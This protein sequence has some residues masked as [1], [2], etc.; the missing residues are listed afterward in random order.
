[1]RISN[2]LRSL[3]IG[4]AVAD[5][6]KLFS[7]VDSNFQQ[8]K[9]ALESKL[10]FG[11][12]I[13]CDIVTT[14]FDSGAPTQVRLN[15]LKMARSGILFGSAV[16]TFGPVVVS[17]SGDGAAVTLYFAQNAKSVTATVVLF[18]F[19]TSA[20]PGSLI[21]TAGASGLVRPDGS[22]ITISDTGVISST[23][24]VPAVR[25]VPPDAYDDIVWKLDELATP[26][27]NSG[28]LGSSAAYQL[29]GFGTVLPGHTALFGK[30][31]AQGYTNTDGMRGAATYEPTGTVCVS[32]WAWYGVAGGGAGYGAIA[33]GDGFYKGYRPVGS[34]AAPF[35]ALECA[36]GFA[37]VC[38]GGAAHT[39]NANSIWTDLLPLRTWSHFGATYDPVSGTLNCF[40]NG[41]LA[42]STVIGGAGPVDY[43]THGVWNIGGNQDNAGGKTL[44]IFDELRIASNWVVGGV[45][46]RNEAYFTNIYNSGLGLF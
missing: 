22:T 14:K 10:T 7:L 25:R 39:L 19:G 2:L 28:G 13:Q 18:D 41:R 36:P 35:I 9:K 27:L 4:S 20:G 33:S 43:G 44:A 45:G 3:E 11:D 12:N 24:G 23:S 29:N 5:L 32:Y 16:P 34:W 8:I 37:A 21:A 1:M 38:I 30:G 15:H 26:F 42:A 46:D 6:K 40:I 31:V 17:P